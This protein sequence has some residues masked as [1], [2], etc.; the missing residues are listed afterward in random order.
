MILPR[1]TIEKVLD[2]PEG[3]TTTSFSE[4]YK[5]Q[6]IS[7]FE[8]LHIF[9]RSECEKIIQKDRETFKE[10]CVLV[11]KDGYVVASAGLSKDDNNRLYLA[12][13][14]IK[15]EEQGNGLGQYLVS[16]VSYAYGTKPSRYPLYAPVNTDL[17]REITLLTR[18]HYLPFFG[19]LNG[20]SEEE[21]KQDWLD[22]AEML[23]EKTQKN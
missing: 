2:L 15:E 6:W 14:G 23:K 4:K 8:S 17:Y 20:K 19:E 16:K 3:Y 7:L 10:Y 13:I 18:M 5:E 11:L 12:F 1:A 21:S 22:I 9:S